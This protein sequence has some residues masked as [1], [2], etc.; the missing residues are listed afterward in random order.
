MLVYIW[1]NDQDKLA[2]KVGTGTTWEYYVLIGDT[3]VKVVKVQKGKAKERMAADTVDIHPAQRYLNMGKR[4][5]ITQ[6]AE[7]FLKQAIDKEKIDA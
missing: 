5:G 3:G 1:Y 7:T 4:L 6:S 2:Y